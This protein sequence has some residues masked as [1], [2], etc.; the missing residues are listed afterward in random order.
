MYL[1]TKVDKDDDVRRFLND[2]ISMTF[3]A[4]LLKEVFQKIC[5]MV[6]NHT[7]MITQ[8]LKDE[9]IHVNYFSGIP[10]ISFFLNQKESCK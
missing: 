9:L 1:N 2:Y 8:I 7:N 4:F 6:E 3:H 10:K 5:S